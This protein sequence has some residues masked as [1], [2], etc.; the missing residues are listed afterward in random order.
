[1]F[2]YKE[3]CLG[4]GGVL[5]GF[6]IVAGSLENLPK[7]DVIDVGGGR[8]EL[9]VFSDFQSWLGVRRGGFHEDLRHV[10]K[11]REIFQNRIKT[12]CSMTK[13]KRFVEKR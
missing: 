6:P 1:M 11:W 12:K 8:E 3:T 4:G 10:K 2:R 9:E 7:Y 13:E 5:G